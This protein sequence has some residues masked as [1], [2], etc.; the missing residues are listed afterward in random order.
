MARYHLHAGIGAAALAIVLSSAACTSSSKTASS[1]SAPASPTSTTQGTE[2]FCSAYEAL[3]ASVQHLASLN[4]V[5]VGTNGLK[6]AADDVKQKAAA[7]ASAAGVFAPQVNAVT[8]P[9]EQLE[10]TLRNLPSNGLRGALPTIT[11]QVTAIVTASRQLASAVT[12][13][14]PTSTSS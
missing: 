10:S 7:L 6:A 4:V 12:T 2:Q 9:I 11:S 8:A 3:N 13:A 1:P 5:A 14:C